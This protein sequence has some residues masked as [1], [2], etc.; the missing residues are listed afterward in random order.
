VKDPDNPF[1]VEILNYPKKNQVKQTA[2]A[3][4]KIPE[5]KVKPPKIQIMQGDKQWDP[6]M[7][8]ER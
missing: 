6:S 5:T 2:V 7:Q 8:K 4:K 1:C 3:E